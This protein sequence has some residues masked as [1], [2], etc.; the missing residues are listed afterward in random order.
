MKAIERFS[1]AAHSGDYASWPLRTP[2]YFDSRASSLKVSGYQLL[3]QFETIAGYLIVTDYDCPFEEAVSF[4]LIDSSLTRILSER[5]IGAPYC[6]CWL[7]S[8]EWTDERH[9]VVMIDGMADRWE[10]TLRNWGIPFL[11]PRLKMVRI[12]SV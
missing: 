10:S 4:T 1:L 12:R 11:R 6:S 7:K 2:L 9:F 3:H 5:R 8:I